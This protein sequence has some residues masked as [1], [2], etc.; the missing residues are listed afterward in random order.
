MLCF[1]CPKLDG[2]VSRAVCCME[3]RLPAPVIELR[4]GDQ[5]RTSKAPP[6]RAAR[7]KADK[8]RRRP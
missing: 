3:K 5:Q 1:D 8:L 4:V 6:N 7:R 2:T